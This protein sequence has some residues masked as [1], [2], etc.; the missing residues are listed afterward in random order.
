MKANELRV[1][2]QIKSSEGTLIVESVNSEGVN[3]LVNYQDDEASPYWYFEDLKGISIS[4]KHLLIFGF[5]AVIINGQKVFRKDGFIF[6]LR[7][8]KT[9]SVVS[10][11]SNEIDSFKIYHV[12]ELQ[13]LYFELTKKEL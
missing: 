10:H 9:G 11:G 13:N 8:S 5:K 7:V 4:E 3:L 12:H 2:N 6:N 1:G